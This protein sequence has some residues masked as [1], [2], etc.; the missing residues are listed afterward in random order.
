MAAAMTERF[1]MRMDE[2]IL[3]RV[4]RWRDAQEGVPSRAEAMRRLIELGLER[5]G[6]E[7]VKFTDG[8]KALLLMVRDIL[9]HLEVDSEV[10]ADFLSEVIYGGH[11]WAPK[12]EMQGL[13]HGEED[14][15]NDVHFVVEVMA[16]WSDIER[17]YAKLSKKDRE[18]VEKDAYPFGAR[19]EFEGFD[20]NNESSLVGI[21][22]FLVRKMGRFDEFADRDL[23]S[24]MPRVDMYRRMVKTWKPLRSATA[25]SGLNA[26]QL[27]R[28]LKAMK[29]GD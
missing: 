8:E 22:R 18:K 28:I 20:G 24:H 10:N 19:V 14:D 16:M 29:Y 9:K 13:F 1:E 3:E 7:S 15:P 23:N 21:A 6:S 25:G 17:S 5:G 26:T 11:Y 12:W 4:D 2:D 27:I